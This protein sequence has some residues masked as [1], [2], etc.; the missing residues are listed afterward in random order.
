MHRDVIKT[1]LSLSPGRI[2][3]LSCNPATFARDLALL[4][5]GYQVEEVQPIDMF[6]HTY[7]IESV[8]RLE[9]LP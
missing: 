2:V 9:K 3:Y 6:P 7:H 1:V 8:A 4:K 5:E